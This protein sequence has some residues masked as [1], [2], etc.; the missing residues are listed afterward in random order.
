MLLVM[1]GKYQALDS[2]FTLDKMKKLHQQNLSSFVYRIIVF[3]SSEQA[4]KLIQQH[5]CYATGCTL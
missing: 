4:L 2:I 3:A 1:Q 5:F